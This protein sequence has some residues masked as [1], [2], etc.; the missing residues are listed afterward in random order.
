MLHRYSESKKFLS[1]LNVVGLVGL[2]PNLR[3]DKEP[4]NLNCL[5]IR[6]DR[7][8]KALQREHLISADVRAL[9]DGTIS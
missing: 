7:L 4:E 6:L 1:D 8:K 9:F 5:F 2:R 3:E